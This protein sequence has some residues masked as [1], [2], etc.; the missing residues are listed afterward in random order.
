MNEGTLQIEILNYGFTYLELH[1]FWQYFINREIKPFKGNREIGMQVHE[2]ST[3]VHGSPVLLK[4]MG[5]PISA[6]LSTVEAI[7]PHVRSYHLVILHSCEENDPDHHKMKHFVS[8]LKKHGYLPCKTKNLPLFLAL[9]NIP[10]EKKTIT[11][12]TSISFDD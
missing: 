11:G 2:F 5:I 3:E 8:L 6:H 10:E 1:D 9:T 7:I 4:I 12:Q